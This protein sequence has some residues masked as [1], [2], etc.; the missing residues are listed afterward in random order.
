MQSWEHP[1][2]TESEEGEKFNFDGV[3]EDKYLNFL[4]A[5]MINEQELLILYRSKT[6]FIL[7]LN[8]LNYTIVQMFNK[9]K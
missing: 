1:L 2:D 5:L 6:N 8:V 7:E 3:H 9:F 4:L